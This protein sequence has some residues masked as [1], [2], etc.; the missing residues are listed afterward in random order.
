MPGGGLLISLP[1]EAS[2]NHCGGGF[3]RLHVRAQLRVTDLITLLVLASPCPFRTSDLPV[4]SRIRR[5][6]LRPRSV[7]ATLRRSLSVAPAC[8][9]AEYPLSSEFPF[10]LKRLGRESAD[11]REKERTK[12]SGK[13][14]LTLVI[15]IYP[16][17]VG[18]I[19][20]RGRIIESC[21]KVLSSQGDD[22]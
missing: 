22:V 18:K 17:L 1:D 2:R 11:C 12:H 9:S 6:L 10:T 3:A 5:S 16:S 4:S 15:Y 21:A 13:N 14:V 8:E 7:R 20:I 19:C